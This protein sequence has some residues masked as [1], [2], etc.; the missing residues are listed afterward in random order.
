[1]R[2][3]TETPTWGFVEK[4]LA[5][6]YPPY[7]PEKLN[8]MKKLVGDAKPPFTREEGSANRPKGVPGWVYTGGIAVVGILAGLLYRQ[9]HGPKV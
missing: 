7:T 9:K 5:A 2:S 1:L 6:R 4:L 8:A 3:V